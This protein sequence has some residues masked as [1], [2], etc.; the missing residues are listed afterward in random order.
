MTV[1][2]VKKAVSDQRVTPDTIARTIVLFLALL[3]QTLAFI[4]KGRIEI[5]E[6]DVYQIVTVVATIVTS[7]VSWW[8][9]NS[10]S[11]AAMAGDFVMKS[12]KTGEDEE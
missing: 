12:I 1:N 2:E 5:A 10:F 7:L 3:N 8:K 11:K 9:N 4:G 6:N